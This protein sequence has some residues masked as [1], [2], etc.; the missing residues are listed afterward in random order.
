MKV[1]VYSNP[2]CGPCRV[3]KRHLDRREIE[4]EERAA[5]EYPEIARLA[6]DKGWRLQAPIVAVWDEMEDGLRLRDIWTE[7]QRGRIDAL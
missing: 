7:Y 6:I 3:T 4:Y 1:I 2:G 5:S